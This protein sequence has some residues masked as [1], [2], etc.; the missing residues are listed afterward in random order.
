MGNVFLL[1]PNMWSIRR[2]FN[3]KNWFRDPTHINMFNPSKMKKILKE[4]NFINIWSRFKIPLFLQRGTGEKW[5]M[6]YSGPFW[7]VRKCFFL[8]GI[9]FFL[10][11]ATPFAYFR[12]VI[13]ILA[14]VRKELGSDC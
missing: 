1:T 9:L 14:Q 3:R 5:I 10:F 2:L 7:I 4:N 12:D 6:P 8:Q 13:H 11:T